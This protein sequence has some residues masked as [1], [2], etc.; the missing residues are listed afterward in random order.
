MDLNQ[1]SAPAGEPAVQPLSSD[2]VESVAVE[3]AEPAERPV[4]GTVKALHLVLQLQAGWYVLSALV[5]VVAY[6]VRGGDTPGLQPYPAFRTHPITMVV[7]A[8]VVG[9]LLFELSRRIPKTPI[10]LHRF[11]TLVEFVLI[12]DGVVGLLLGIFDIWWI[13]ALLATTAALFYARSED[14]VDYL[15]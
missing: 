10:G 9:G 5:A 14:T 12:V 7:V 2:P 13:V 6:L 11:I 8:L 3:L 4:P 15:D 1:E